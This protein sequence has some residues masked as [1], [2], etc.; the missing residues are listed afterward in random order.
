MV[1]ILGMLMDQPHLEVVKEEVRLAQ[2][3]KFK[4]FME[5]PWKNLDNEIQTLDFGFWTL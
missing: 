2:T 5:Q 4:R 3:Y 1:R